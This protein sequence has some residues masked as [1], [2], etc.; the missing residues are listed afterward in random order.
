MR[1]TIVLVCMIDGLCECAWERAAPQ[2]SFL[3]ELGNAAPALL[4]IRAL[5][6]RS[7]ARV[8]T[9]AHLS[10]SWTSQDAQCVCGHAKYP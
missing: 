10:G 6:P 5:S 8:L 1:D 4:L 7:R 9:H 2:M 3:G